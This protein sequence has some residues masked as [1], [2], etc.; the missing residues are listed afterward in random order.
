MAGVR[1]VLD[2]N[3]LISAVL[4]LVHG[5]EHSP[6]SWPTSMTARFWNVLS[7]AAQTI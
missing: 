3:V 4:S 2:T 6:S 5:R 1:V 7:T